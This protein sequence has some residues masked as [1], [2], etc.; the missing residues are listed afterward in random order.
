MFFQLCSITRALFHSQIRAYL[1][2]CSVLVALGKSL[3]LICKMDI[4]ILCTWQGCQY[5]WANACSS[6]LQTI[7]GCCQRGF[8]CCYPYVHRLLTI[9][10]EAKGGGSRQGEGR[11][12]GRSNVH[13]G[14]LPTP[15]L[16]SGHKVWNRDVHRGKR[17]SVSEK[18]LHASCT[19]GS[20]VLSSE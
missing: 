9:L 2:L 7:K 4:I 14:A 15:E 5:N 3:N 18:Y 16:Y 6:A 1:T 20:P 8:Y 13:G 11:R 17:K 12:T 19:T 10:H